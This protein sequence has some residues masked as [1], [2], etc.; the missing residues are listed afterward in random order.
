M[1]KQADRFHK[2]GSMGKYLHRRNKSGAGNVLFYF[3]KTFQKITMYSRAS[4]SRTLKNPNNLVSYIEEFI[5]CVFIMGLYN[6]HFLCI[7]VFCFFL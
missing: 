6:R 3:L 1:G 5:K 7:L 4:F 2:N